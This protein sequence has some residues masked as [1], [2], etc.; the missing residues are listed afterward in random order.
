MSFPKWKKQSDE[1]KEKIRQKMLWRII[2]N[3][4]IQKMKQSAKLLWESDWHKE[5]MSSIQSWENHW[6]YQWWITPL[7]KKIRKCFK[8]RQWRSDVF[9]RDEFCCV[10]CWKKWWILQ[11]DHIK[12]FSVIMNENNI[13]SLEE[14][15]CCEELW[16]INNWQT[17]CLA[18][19][20]V[21]TK[22]DVNIL[23]SNRAN[24]G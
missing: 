13:S 4:T 19:H 3:E 9:T 22:E 11:A 21:K 5:Y 18:C 14:A 6:N 7:T 8:Y 1:T 24:N 16:N 23:N 12:L 2:S 15:E 10:S 20:K 17:L